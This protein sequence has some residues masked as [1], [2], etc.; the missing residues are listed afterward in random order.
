LRLAIGGLVTGHAGSLTDVS[1]A[2]WASA[3]AA[4]ALYYGIAFWFYLRG[5]R[6]CSPAIAGLFITADRPS[7][8][9]RGLQAL[10]VIHLANRPAAASEYCLV[11]H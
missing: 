10:G 8:Q 5:L 3:L 4:G 1:A 9:P 7:R 11:R 6:T 2:G